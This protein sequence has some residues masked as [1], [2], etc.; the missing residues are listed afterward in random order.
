MTAPATPLDA[1][2]V[3]LDTSVF[4]NPAV[5]RAFGPTSAQAAHAFT[6]L[7]RQLAQELAFYMPPS[8]H[9]ELQTFLE[10]DEL[11]RDFELVVR[12]RAPKR[13]QI[14]MPGS[15][16]Y[17][18]ID[19]MRERINRGLRAAEEAVRNPG[20]HPPE[21]AIAKLR[22]KY[23]AILRAGIIDSRE[24]VDVLLLAVE[25]DA[26]VVSADLGLT[27]WAERLGLR[28]IH[29]ERL[30]G[31]LAQLIDNPTPD[32]ATDNRGGNPDYSK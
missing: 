25:I 10:P 29:P 8:V 26:A 27:T 31:I 14:Q 11:P 2:A 22:E 1:T 28:I 9:S 16:L 18:L 6:A 12:L 15:L 32:A 20:G 5:A 4:T 24:D 21:R 7:A 30:P 19:D 3:V 13:H 23:R 17:Q